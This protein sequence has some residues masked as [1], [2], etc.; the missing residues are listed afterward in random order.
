MY[1]VKNLILIF[2]ATIAISCTKKETIDYAIISGKILNTTATEIRIWSNDFKVDKKFVIDKDGV[3]SDTIFNSFGSFKFLEA[4]NL[5]VM[6]ITAGDQIN[7]N[8]DAKDFGTTLIFSGKGSQASNYLLAKKKLIA[9][10]IGGPKEYYKLDQTEFKAKNKKNSDA[11]LSLLLNF[12]G[13]SNS[14]IE[15]EKKDINY[16]YLNDLNGFEDNHSYFTKNDNYKVSET[17]LDE[18]NGFDFNIEEDYFS[19][20][21]YS[22]IVSSHYRKL[23]SELAELKQI[24]NDLAFL[25]IVDDIP[26]KKI[27]NDLLTLYVDYI[28]YATDMKEYFD[29]FMKVSTNDDQKKA[30]TKIYEVL[31][32]LDPGNPSPKF[33]GYENNAGGTMSLDDLKGKYVYIDV[34][35]TWCAP[36]KAEI[37][38]LKKVEKQYHGKNIEFVSISIDRDLDHDKW[39]QMIIDKELGGVQLLADKQFKSKFVQDYQIRGIPHFILLDPEGNIVKYSA[40]RPSNEE[41]IDLLDELRI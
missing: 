16:S 39:K 3:F 2:A 4:R 13:L 34:W 31:K 8:Y 14:Y 38:F 30:I 5:N 10:F 36:C 9:E 33:V 32:T 24:D 28:T 12:E 27:K 41:L 29:L 37:P 1:S 26:S 6:N 35:A 23:S 11:V 17:F 25:I 18:M 15:N 20:Q 40:P 21:Y 22:H 19:T 7:I